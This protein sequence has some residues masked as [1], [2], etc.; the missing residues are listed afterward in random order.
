LKSAYSVTQDGSADLTDDFQM[1]ISPGAHLQMSDEPHV[2]KNA[3]LVDGILES[4]PLP[5]QNSRMSV[6]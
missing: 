3:R 4:W 5:A 6:M 2:V 1:T